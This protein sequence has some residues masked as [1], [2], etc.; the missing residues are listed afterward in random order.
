MDNVREY[1][2]AGAAAEWG[3]LE[4]DAFHRLEFTATLTCLHDHLPASGLVLDAGGGPGRYAIELSRRGYSVVLLDLSERS[5][6]LART[7]LALETGLA[8][9]PRAEVGDIRDLSRFPDA[10][11]DAVLC[12]GGPLSHLPCAVD[13]QTAMRELVRVAKPSAPVVLSVIGYYAVLRTV[14]SR[15]PDELAMPEREA[16]LLH[17]DHAGLGGFPDAHFFRPQELQDLAERAGLETVELRACE[18]LSSN[19]G[20]ATNALATFD[21][22]RWERWLRVLEA[23]RTDPA[24]VATSEHFLYVGRAP[25]GQGPVSPDEAPGA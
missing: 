13:R 21:D 16:A 23:T 10:T 12:L 8:Q 4:S 7:K 14:L 1:Y 5:V 11:F 15:A 9:P 2:D 24:V 25:V 19:L 22:G 3:R 6:V 17:G 18:G 20:D